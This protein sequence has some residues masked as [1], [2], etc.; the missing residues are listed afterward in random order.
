MIQLYAKLSDLVPTEPS[1]LD[2]P[3]HFNDP[4]EEVLLDN[5]MDCLKAFKK[6]I[7][8]NAMKY[9]IVISDRGLIQDGN[10]R[11]W[12]AKELGWEYVPVWIRMNGEPFYPKREVM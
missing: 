1:K 9:A 8:L 7:F 2:T 6:D 5:D 4:D 12:C 11:Y 3:T 10:C